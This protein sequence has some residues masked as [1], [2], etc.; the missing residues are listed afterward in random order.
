MSREKR[1][2]LVLLLNVALTGMLL[3]VGLTAH[4]LGVWAQG[5]DYLAD[6][7]AV[8][9][10]LVAIWLSRRPPTARRP[11]G[12]PTATT[13]AALVNGGWLLTLSVVIGVA[14][15]QRLLS[16][17]TR[18]S[19]LPV[20]LVSALAAVVMASGALILKGADGGGA[21]AGGDD[22]ADLTMAAVVLDTAADAMAAAGV[23][24]AGG[25]ILA[26]GGWFWLDPA[27][28]LVIAVV[29]GY[30]AAGLVSSIVSSLR[31]AAPGKRAP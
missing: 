20:I 28:A 8:G 19:A 23:A 10:S 26:T 24:V 11:L 16:H 13:I 2:A 21:D 7:A 18:V 4:S 25:V 17:A 12:Y 14:A 27:V 30:R 1:L 5:V 22:G 31:E 3:I 15:A 9:L 29:V 6:A